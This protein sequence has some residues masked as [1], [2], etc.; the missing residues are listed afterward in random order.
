MDH[1][2][3]WVV[4]GHGTIAIE[5]DPMWG[6]GP[7]AHQMPVNFFILKAPLESIHHPA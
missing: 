5:G 7:L 1:R 4:A 2:A 6:R 3:G